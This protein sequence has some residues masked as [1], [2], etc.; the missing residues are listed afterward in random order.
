MV[1]GCFETIRSLSKSHVDI[2]TD[3]IILTLHNGVS[4]FLKAIEI[5]VQVIGFHSHPIRLFELSFEA[6]RQ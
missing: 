1:A 2:L 3:K 6:A 5:A 4:P